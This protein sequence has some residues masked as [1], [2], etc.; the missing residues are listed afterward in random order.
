MK[1]V[2]LL[3]IQLLAAAYLIITGPVITANLV[4]LS[5]EVLTL[6][7]II[8]TLWTIMFNKFSL[9][10]PKLKEARLIPKGPFVYVR[11][12]VYT[13][14]LILA[15][16][17]IFNYVSVFKLLVFVV[18]VASVILTVSYYERILSKNLSDF[19]LYKQ[20]TY[21]IFHMSIK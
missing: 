5:F 3:F 13:A 14:L 20:K 12:P 10:N 17:W 16:C 2:P 4:I 1:L 7:L 19:G 11:H 15:I 8:W 6:F 18:L 9:Y 21:K